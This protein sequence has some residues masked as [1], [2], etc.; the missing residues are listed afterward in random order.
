[1][2]ISPAIVWL[3]LPPFGLHLINTGLTEQLIDALSKW[4]CMPV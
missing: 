2:T 3:G 4:R 1:V